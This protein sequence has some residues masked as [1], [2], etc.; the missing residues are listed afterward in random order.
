MLHPELA[1]ALQR[2]EDELRR[3]ERRRCNLLIGSSIA[4]NAIISVLLVTAAIASQNAAPLKGSQ[5]AEDIL[6]SYDSMT[7]AHNRKL[8]QVRAVLTKFRAYPWQAWGAAYPWQIVQ[9]GRRQLHDGR[10]R[11]CCHSDPP[12]LQVNVL[13]QCCAPKNG[14]KLLH[15]ALVRPLSAWQHSCDATAA[16]GRDPPCPAAPPDHAMQACT[17][18]AEALAPL[19]GS[20]TLTNGKVV[21]A[22]P[23][24]ILGA[25]TI[26]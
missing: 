7:R 23:V 3:K 14:W 11:Y 24:D 17:C 16:S 19:V 5:T 22:K 9:G 12:G 26:K 25:V 1:E 8:Q 4:V 20:I 10:R 21:I 15:H 18:V 2:R 13:H 6:P